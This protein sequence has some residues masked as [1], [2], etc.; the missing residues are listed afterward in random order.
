MP[1]WRPRRDWKHPTRAASKACSART[2]IYRVGVDSGLSCGGHY[3]GVVCARVHSPRLAIDGEKQN[4]R[5]RIKRSSIWS[6]YDPF[7]PTVVFLWPPSHNSDLWP[8][9]FTRRE[10]DGFCSASSCVPLC[11]FS[12]CSSPRRFWLERVQRIEPGGTGVTGCY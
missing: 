2:E 12:A 3:R 7:G 1:P 8:F 6:G 10:L 4:N 11:H 5:E 9:W